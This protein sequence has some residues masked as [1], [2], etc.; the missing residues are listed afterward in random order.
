MTADSAPRI[1]GTDF[2]VASGAVADGSDSNALSATV[3]DAHGNFLSDVDVT[4]T[5]TEGAA[6]PATQIVKTDDN[7][8]AKAQIVSTVV[9]ENQVTVTSLGSSPAPKVSA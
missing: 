9:G 5:V 8:V 7:G 3:R 1:D 4:F 2:I 6:T